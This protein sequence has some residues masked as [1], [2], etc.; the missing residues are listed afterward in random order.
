VD[1]REASVISRL[2]LSPSKAGTKMKTSDTTRKTCQCCKHQIHLIKTSAIFLKKKKVPERI[3]WPKIQSE[4]GISYTDFRGKFRNTVLGC[5]LLRKNFQN[6]VPACSITKIPLIKTILGNQI[7]DI[8]D[9]KTEML[10][11]NVSFNR[12]QP[13]VP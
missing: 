6:G 13:T 4:M 9:Q 2:P 3:E 1:S 7:Q 10:T 8:F 11:Y 12:H 5:I